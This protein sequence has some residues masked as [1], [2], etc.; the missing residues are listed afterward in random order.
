MDSVS[1]L[2]EKR[3]PHSRRISTGAGDEVKLAKL[4]AVWT[5]SPVSADTVLAPQIG[6]L[7]SLPQRDQAKLPL[8]LLS[9]FLSVKTM[10]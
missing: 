10:Q 1:A 6:L 7:A 9:K 2:P 8:S 4:D 3:P 5:D